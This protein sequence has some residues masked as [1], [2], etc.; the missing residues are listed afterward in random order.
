MNGFNK[1]IRPLSREERE[2]IRISE[3]EK[4]SRADHRPH[5]FDKEGKKSSPY[6]VT[7][8]LLKK[9]V[10]F[11]TKNRK[12]LQ[13]NTDLATKAHALLALLQ[14][15]GEKDQSENISYIQKLSQIWEQIIDHIEY[16]KLTTH[17]PDN[18]HNLLSAIAG[19]N[20]FPKDAEYSFGFYLLKHA[21]KE[22]FPFPFMEMLKDLH[23]N[24]QQLKEKSVLTK[25]TLDLE[26]YLKEEED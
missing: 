24:H 18:I 20:H 21:G 19:M 12:H 25:W 5:P 6:Q 14:Q 17:L 1:P 13:H 15:L 16:L 4:L 11:F 3:I 2:K 10:H 8:F 9:L 23:Q 7:L 26:R 22:W